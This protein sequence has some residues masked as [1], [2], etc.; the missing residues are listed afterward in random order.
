MSTFKKFV[1]FFAFGV[2]VISLVGIIY[3]LFSDYPQSKIWWSVLTLA[4]S[5]GVGY[6]AY[7]K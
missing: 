2:A 7:K 1:L 5:S 3:M 6:W 4:V